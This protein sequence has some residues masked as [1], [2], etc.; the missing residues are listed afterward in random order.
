VHVCAGRDT[1]E[2]DEGEGECVAH[3]VDVCVWNEE[4]KSFR[5]Q[6]DRAETLSDERKVRIRGVFDE[7]TPCEEDKVQRSRGQSYGK[8]IVYFFQY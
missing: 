4:G 8:A 6:N 5:H 3:C 7:N 2:S 1:Q